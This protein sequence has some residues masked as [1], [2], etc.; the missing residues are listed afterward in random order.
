MLCIRSGFFLH[1]AADIGELRRG[2]WSLVR[3]AFASFF[4]ALCS[5]S[6]PSLLS[7]FCVHRRCRR[8]KRG[9]AYFC[10]ARVPAR[11]KAALALFPSPGL[12]SARP[13][14]HRR[15]RLFFFVLCP[16]SFS[17][18][19]PVCSGR[20]RVAFLLRLA[21]RPAGGLPPPMR[22]VTS[23]PA[24]RSPC[25]LSFPFARGPSRSRSLLAL[26]RALPCFDPASLPPCPASP[27]V[28][29]SLRSSRR[30]RGLTG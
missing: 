5:Y 15:A 13:L 4:L 27:R 12:S 29:A 19:F 22:C 7:P 1:R 3:C 28:L 9:A 14:R 16:A 8:G 10:G 26:L 20:R 25:A 24:R 17:S 2:T 23:R 11:E 18:F 21:E 30:P 6:H